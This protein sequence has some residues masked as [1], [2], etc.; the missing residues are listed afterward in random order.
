MENKILSSDVKK[1]DCYIDFIESRDIGNSTKRTYMHRITR[2][3][4]FLGKT[5]TELI[6]EAEDEQDSAIKTRKRRI[7]RYLIDYKKYLED[8]GTTNTAVK[9]NITTVKS[10]YR[11]LDIDVPSIKFKKQNSNISLEE[12]ISIDL[13]KKIVDIANLRDKAIVLLM[14]SSGMGAAEVKNLTYGDFLR[15]I[16]EYIELNKSNYFDIELIYD[17]LKNQNNLIG[18]WKIHRV[19]TGKP[20][21]TFNSP[22]STDA[23]LEYLSERQRHNIA[24]KSQEDPLFI[25]DQKKKLSDMAFLYIFHRLNDKLKL[26]FRSKNRR[27]FTSH[28]LRKFFTTTL[29]SNGADK[30][31]VDWFL[32]HS[33]H[34][35]TESYFKTNEKDLKNRYTKYVNHLML[36]K[37]KIERISSEEVK[38]IVNELN[39]K[40]EQLEQMKDEQKLKDAKMEAKVDKLEEMVLEMLKNVK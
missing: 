22:E 40:D 7:K 35:T 26:G 39:K 32:G 9:I 33:I 23:I 11:S 28:Q 25:S 18:T 12:T 34:S 8:E 17:K 5:P 24:P 29:Y 4:N 16:L 20:Y 6:E 36:K 1:D 31:V 2:Y 19:K 10:F 38:N 21:Y 3:C 37:V 14:L 30:L 15:G 27:V 13:I